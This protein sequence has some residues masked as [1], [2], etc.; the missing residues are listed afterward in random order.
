MIKLFTVNKKKIYFHVKSKP[1]NHWII[2]KNL[3]SYLMKAWILKMFT[4]Q[5]SEAKMFLCG[6]PWKRTASYHLLSLT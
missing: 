4:S 1:T 3:G 5:I 6:Q 2:I